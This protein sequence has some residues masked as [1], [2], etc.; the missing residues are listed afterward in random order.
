[1]TKQEDANKLRVSLAAA[2]LSAA[3]AEENAKATLD[4]Q[5]VAGATVTAAAGMPS[6][7][8]TFFGFVLAVGPWCAVIPVN[9]VASLLEARDKLAEAIRS[10]SKRS[11]RLGFVHPSAL[12]LENDW[13][14]N[15]PV[16]QKA[17]GELG[18][19]K[20]RSLP[21]ARTNTATTF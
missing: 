11:R 16:L 13:A 21:P 18:K 20:A 9:H 15:L 5:D 4:K 14:N 12:I 19:A 10:T 8:L 1:M 17:Q 6:D 7:V 2:Q 3:A